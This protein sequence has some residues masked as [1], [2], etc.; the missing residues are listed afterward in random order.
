MKQVKTWQDFFLEL[1]NTLYFKNIKTLVETSDETLVFPKKEDVFR[2]FQFTPLDK[3]KVVILGQ[4]PYHQPGQAMGL[5]FSVPH[6]FKLPPSLRNIFKEM[7]DDIGGPLMSDG[8][9]TYLAKQG[10]FLFNTILTV[11]KD[12]PLSHANEHY[13]AFTKDVISALNDAP[14]PIVFILWGTYA[15]TFKK[16]IK[17]PKKFIIE[18]NH[19]S[20]L[21]ANRG[22]FFGLKYFSKTNEFLSKNGV[23]PIDWHK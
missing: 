8:D 15:K 13:A 5:A 22:G 19:P 2:A 12:N 16:H 10:V 7:H 1:E 4:D 11:Q 18:G 21:S 14:Q 3:V 20:P 9:L 17:G 23:K 6:G